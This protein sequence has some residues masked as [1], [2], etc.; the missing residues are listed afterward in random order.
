MDAGA[1]HDRGYCA[2]GTRGWR[3]GSR[4]VGG[5]SNARAR[6]ALRRLALRVVA[7]RAA[8]RGRKNCERRGGV[9][10]TILGERRFQSGGATGTSR[11][12]TMKPMLT[13][14]AVVLAASLTVAA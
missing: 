9:G 8:Q 1:L 5:A 7:R 3:L 11:D 4:G 2:R 10:G 14:L 6:R 12:T 13:L